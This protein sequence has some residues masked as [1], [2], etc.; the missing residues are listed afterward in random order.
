[1]DLIKHSRFDPI[2][3]ERERQVILQEFAMTEEDPEE[4]IHDVLFEKAFG[5]H[6][7]GRNIL[8]TVQ[9]VKNF[10]RDDVLEYFSRHYYSRNIIITM[11]GNV[12]HDFVVRRLNAL[13]G[14]FRGKKN[15]L[16]KESL[17]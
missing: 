9:T 14:D 17:K 15:P 1:A 6:S 2:E 13:L 4:F 7:L 10:T 11:A 12:D 16:P 3:I 5:K 8:G